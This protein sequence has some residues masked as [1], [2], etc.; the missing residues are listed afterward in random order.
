MSD[1]QSLPPQSNDYSPDD[2]MSTPGSLAP[3][4]VFEATDPAETD[5]L[6]E[7]MA[8]SATVGEEVQAYR[9]L[10][11]AILHSTPPVQ[12]P[13]EA[14]EKL[15][16]AIQP[17]VAPIAQRYPGATAPV[18]P[19]EAMQVVP[20]VTPPGGK[21]AS[22]NRINPLT[23]KAV[24]G[25]SA[26]T[27]G[28]YGNAAAYGAV[29]S[30]QQWRPPI[31]SQPP[32]QQSPYHPPQYAPP[33][34]QAPL[35]RVQYKQPAPKPAP[36]PQNAAQR[37]A[38]SAPQYVTTP[39]PPG[40][41]GN[42]VPAGFALTPIPPEGAQGSSASRVGMWAAW[43]LALVALGLLFA[44][45]T[46]WSAQSTQLAQE[47]ARL[48]ADVTGAQSAATSTGSELSAAQQSAQASATQV[49]SLQESLATTQAELATAQSEL[50]TARTE[51]ADAAALLEQVNANAGGMAISDEMINV[52]VQGPMEQATLG[53]LNAS[54]TMSATA[55]ILWNP[56]MQRGML[57]A[58]QM[59]PLP[60]DQAYQLWLLRG[61]VPTAAGMFT[62]DDR[63]M[64][65]LEVNDMDLSD[66]EVAAVTPEPMAGSEAP[67]GAILIAGEL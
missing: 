24:G 21:A 65:M 14:G 12:L 33:A 42:N 27:S 41:K 7:E 62:V 39:R 31:Q 66:Y 18:D 54:Q 4:Y 48:Q 44:S 6:R 9:R 64:G 15:L 53:A 49:A 23:G 32:L 46:F 47:N 8:Q 38:G 40:N 26:T 50:E 67:T 1:N 22:G 45:Y 58:M 5:A 29:A 25:S 17:P 34:K 11:N 3:A 63:G 51:L 60:Q 43:A 2:Q 56:E 52:L 61:G 59:P 36:P 16:A 57:V 30:S 19:L 55:R 20:L 37:G 13:P 35:T 28:A 10:F